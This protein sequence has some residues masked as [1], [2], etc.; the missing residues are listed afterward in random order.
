MIYKVEKVYRVSPF[1]EF[2][3]GLQLLQ[4]NI[5]VTHYYYVKE[6]ILREVYKR[7]S[8]IARGR[9]DGNGKPLLSNIALT[10]D[11]EQIM[12]SFLSEVSYIAYD[13]LHKHT[14]GIRDSFHFYTGFD[15]A[16]PHPTLENTFIFPKDKFTVIDP[17]YLPSNISIPGAFFGASDD[18]WYNYVTGETKD[19]EYVNVENFDMNIR[20]TLWQKAYFSDDDEKLLDRSIFEL[21]VRYVLWKWIQYTIPAE[22]QTFEL[23]YERQFV[24]FRNRVNAQS[25]AIE[26]TYHLF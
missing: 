5:G 4:S 6:D 13:E 11:D 25:S 7:T 2:R 12:M 8:Y 9:V 21:F 23:E 15:W 16:I 18:A 24:A 22:A 1:S 26:R 14:H 20:Y 3:D 10:T 19:A 17:S